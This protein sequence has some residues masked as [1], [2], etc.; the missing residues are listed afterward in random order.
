M[1]GVRMVNQK[2]YNSEMLKALN[3]I[4]EHSKKKVLDDF[5]YKSVSE[6]SPESKKEY[7]KKVDKVELEILHEFYKKMGIL[8]KENIALSKNTSK[9]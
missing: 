5:G 6:I 9:T 8:N 4:H 1:N 7:F 2:Q 3:K